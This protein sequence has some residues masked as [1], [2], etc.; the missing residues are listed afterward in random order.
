MKENEKR[1]LWRKDNKIEGLKKT[2]DKDWRFIQI[3]EKR[4]WEE[5]KA[6]EESHRREA[7][8]NELSE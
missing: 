1:L 8:A 5:S 4:S 3:F 6:L 7:C 2:G